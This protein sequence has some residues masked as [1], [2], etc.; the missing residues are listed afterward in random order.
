MQGFSR[1]IVLVVGLDA[2]M[3][4]LLRLTVIAIGL[5]K[6]V[7]ANGSCTAP[8]TP[9]SIVISNGRNVLVNNSA[10]L[11]G[12]VNS[13]VKPVLASPLGIIANNGGYI[14]YNNVNPNVVKVRVASNSSFIGARF[15]ASNTS[16][17]YG[18]WEYPLN[19]L[20]SNDNIE[21]DLKGL[22]N[23]VGIN[24]SNARAPFFIT[25]AGY[26]VYADT[27]SMGS[28]DFTS[29]G[30]AQFIFNTSSLIYYIITPA[31]PGDYKS[32]IEEYT[33]LSSR[34]EMPPDSGYGPTFWSDDFEQDFHGSV[35]NAQENYYDV[36]NHLYYNEI[37]A[38]SMFAD[39]KSLP[40][41]S[42]IDI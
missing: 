4:I 34:I 1:P 36:I 42:L 35:S 39:R 2:N 27:L 22:G 7:L 14:A 31:S 6:F 40:N 19:D 32:I 8:V 37:R 10:I 41:Y 23:S 30:Q 9:Y 18:V 11:T 21:F 24:W 38:T 15:T 13:T 25:N 29:P 28:F 17:F 5:F 16:L 3:D 26:G 33:A 12:T 20:I